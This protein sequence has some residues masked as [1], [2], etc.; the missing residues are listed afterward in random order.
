MELPTLKGRWLDLVPLEEVHIPALMAIARANPK[1]FR[2]TSTPITDEQCERYFTR[3]F[4][5]MQRQEAAVFTLV[6]QQERKIIGTS[7]LTDFKWQHRNCELGYTWIDVA[8]RGT[9]V[10]TDSKYQLL[11]WAFEVLKLLR[12]EIHT[13]IRNSHSQRAIEK[14]GA[15]YEGTLRRHQVAKEGYIRDTM[16]YSIVDLDW[17]LVKRALLEQLER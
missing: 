17:P 3:A 4:E 10:N 12:V 2:F 1:A 15:V 7:R 6:H 8:Y 9:G 11:A 5:L 14:L 16:V 13:D